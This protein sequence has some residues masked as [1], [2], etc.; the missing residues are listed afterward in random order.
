MGRGALVVVVVGRG[1]LVVV[2]V[3][4]GALVV[5]V[6]GAL[7]V[8][9]VGALVVVVTFVVVTMGF[10]VVVA[11]V[12][13]VVGLVVVVAPPEAPAM[14]DALRLAMV[15]P[16]AATAGGTEVDDDGVLEAELGGV[17]TVVSDPEPRWGAVVEP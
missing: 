13:V 10:V 16:F 4:R 2:V 8:V 14:S 12:V 6:V 3:G 1:A 15:P 17:P 11:L 7:V 5:V 9:V